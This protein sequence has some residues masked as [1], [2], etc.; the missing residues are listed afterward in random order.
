MV[1]AVLMAMVSLPAKTEMTQAVSQ[2]TMLLLEVPLDVLVANTLVVNTVV[3]HTATGQLRLAE[4]TVAMVL[5][6]VSLQ[7]NLAMVSQLARVSHLARAS[8]QL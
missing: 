4:N 3:V 2:A 7:P 6:P 5:P 8:L 1:R